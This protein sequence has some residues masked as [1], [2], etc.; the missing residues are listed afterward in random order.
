VREEEICWTHESEALRVFFTSCN[1]NPGMNSLTMTS[2][3]VFL[4]A[5][6]CCRIS[7]N[8]RFRFMNLDVRLRKLVTFAPTSTSYKCSTASARVRTHVRVQ[9]D[10]LFIFLY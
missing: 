5:G 8:K 9:L 2:A 6:Q 4:V 7:W 3:G 10:N 1:S